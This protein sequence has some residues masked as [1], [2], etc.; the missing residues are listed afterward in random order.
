MCVWGVSSNAQPHLLVVEDVLGVHVDQADV[1][2]QQH[3]H[4]GLGRVSAEHPPIEAGLLRE[5]RQA[6]RVVEVEVRH[7]QEV[8]LIGCLGVQEYQG[9]YE[10]GTTAVVMKVVL[11]GLLGRKLEMKAHEKKGGG[12]R[13]GGDDGGNTSG[14]F[15]RDRGAGDGSS[16]GSTGGG[17]GGD[18]SG[19][20]VA[21]D[22]SQLLLTLAVSHQDQPRPAHPSPCSV[23]Y[24]TR[25]EPASAVT[26]ACL[27]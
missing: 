15:R 11:L 16:D 9:V 13:G 10:G 14:S 12:G 2:R 3:P 8:D 20:R 24:P 1:V 21:A 25:R 27:T 5:V 22:T 4:D 23:T 18:S 26:S 19:D 7:Q 6:R 17:G